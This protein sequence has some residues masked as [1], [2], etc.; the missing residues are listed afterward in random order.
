ME[1]KSLGS[2]RVASEKLHGRRAETLAAAFDQLVYA[3]IDAV[4]LS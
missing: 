4:T 2:I 1:E 3:G